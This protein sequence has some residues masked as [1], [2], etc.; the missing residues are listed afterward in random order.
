MLATDLPPTCLIEVVDVG[1]SF[2]RQLALGEHAA[3]VADAIWSL[4][5][6]QSKAAAEAVQSRSACPARSTCRA[7][8]ARPASPA[9]PACRACPAWRRPAGAWENLGVDFM[10]AFLEMRR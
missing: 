1:A 5:N 2:P 4:G 3:R 8:P 7:R 9:S 6:S 10:N